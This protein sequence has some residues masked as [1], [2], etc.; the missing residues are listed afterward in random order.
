MTSVLDQKR[1]VVL[2]SDV[3]EELGL[4]EGSEVLFEKRKGVVV[5]KK[6][7]KKEDRLLKAMSWNP[8]RRGK[9]SPV[10]EKEIKEIWG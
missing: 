1:R 7:G 8:K 9:P 10:K 5:M 2:P 4:S 3:I 6:A